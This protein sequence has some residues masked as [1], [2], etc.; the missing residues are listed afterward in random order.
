MPIVRLFLTR[1]AEDRLLLALL[2]GLA[3]LL[4][5]APQKTAEL[6]AL[7]DWRTI[8]ALAGLLVLSRGLEDSGFL[9]RMGRL[10]LSHAQ[11]QRRLAASLVVFSA[12]LSAVIT[13]DVALFIV[14]PLTLSLCSAARMPAG[15]LIIFEALAVNAGST[16]SPVGNPQNL[17]LWQSSSAGFI[18]FTLAMLPLSLALLALILALVPLA[19]PVRRLEIADSAG[20]TPVDARL[21]W[22][23]LALY[24]PFLIAA[25][26]GYTVWAAGGV[27]ALYLALA[28]HVLREVDWLLLLVFVLMFIDLGLLAG[29]PWIAERVPMLLEL[30]GGLLMTGAL[31][32]QAVS[33]VPAAI[34][35]N[36]FTDDWR[37]LAWAVA[38]GGFG[39]AIGSLANLIALRLSRQPHLWREFH[40][41]S[42][43]VLMLAF[44]LAWWLV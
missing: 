17:F 36:T 18:D 7:V 40:L 29:M 41:W 3:A 4:L 1:L 39:T 6:P 23:S 2:A 31:L 20:A 38:V 11:R 25:E 10:L 24:P 28:R 32:S 33:N 19:F 15:R 14:V 34:F 21:M 9:S 43:P 12:A 30:P 27:I 26:F 13:N 22:L 44:G 42:M 5:A 37:T 16:A 35:L 8:A